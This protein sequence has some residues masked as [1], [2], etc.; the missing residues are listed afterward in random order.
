MKI[1]SKNLS[2]LKKK[3]DFKFEIIWWGLMN[4]L[5]ITELSILWKENIANGIC[6]KSIIVLVKG[7]Q[8]QKHF[9]KPVISISVPKHP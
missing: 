9:A 6:K 1:I 7:Q 2:D 8:K 5:E 3:V 4:L